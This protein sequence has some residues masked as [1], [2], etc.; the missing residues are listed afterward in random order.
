MK[1]VTAVLGDETKYR[2][3]IRRSAEITFLVFHEKSKKL[4]GQAPDP[5]RT[6]K[7]LRQLSSFRKKLISSDLGSEPEIAALGNLE[8]YNRII[9]PINLGFIHREIRRRH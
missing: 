9:R 8:I 1:I 4:F 2:E 6:K 5:H 3:V 7:H